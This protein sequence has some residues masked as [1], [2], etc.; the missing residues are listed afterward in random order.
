M[1]LDP[2]KIAAAG[3]PV[4]DDVIAKVLASLKEDDGAAFAAVLQ[5]ADTHEFGCPLRWV[6]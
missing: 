3:K 4:A 6:R 5:L 1:G 2:K